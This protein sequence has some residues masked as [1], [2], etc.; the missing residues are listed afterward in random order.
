MNIESIKKIDFL[1]IVNV[2]LL[3]LIGALNIFATTYFPQKEPSG[4][5]F[6]QIIFYIIGFA[7]LS[8]IAIINFQFFNKAI[9]QIL[10][11][12]ICT[13]LLVSVLIFGEY[14]LGAKRWINIG[15]IT[16]QPSEFAKIGI[17]LLTSYI[18]AIKQPI[19][20]GQKAFKVFFF[21]NFNLIKIIASLIPLVIFIALIIN[22]NSLGNSVLVFGIW[23]I[24]I[25]SYLNINIKALGYFLS[26]VLGF[27]FILN[28]NIF[29]FLFFLSLIFLV[30]KIT[31]AKFLSLVFLF[32]LFMPFKVAFNFGYDYILQD[33]QKTRLEVFFNPE[34]N[35]AANWNR[36]QAEIALGSG[37]IFGKG[38]LKGTHTNYKF[39]PFSYNDF[40]FASIGEQ[41]G[42]IGLFI[43]CMLFLLLL[44]RI[45]KIGQ[46]TIDIFGRLIIYGV[47]GMIFLNMFQHM[48]MNV[49]ILP[50]TGVPLPF[51]SYGGSSTIVMMVGI[52]LILS[53]SIYSDKASK[54]KKH[55]IKTKIVNIEL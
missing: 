25:M 52:G 51:V 14:I 12:L 32:L 13:G 55:Y 7:L 29:I 21:K 46:E 53:I 40:A 49:G 26:L 6:N 47:S 43:I 9:I 50:I 19:N 4:L 8:V 37:K 2:L 28:I 41:F 39:L 18:L 5:F 15:I 10:V 44:N 36:E 20:K 45:I 23:V 31:K 3:C 30:S 1:I 34:K 24:I 42:F 22:Q 33:Y 38:F 27:V 17:I 54:V 48:G 16:I 35:Q 11:F